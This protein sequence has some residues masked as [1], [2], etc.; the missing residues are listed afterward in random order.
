MGEKIDRTGKE[1]VN[2]QGS[3]MIISVYNS[4]KNIT[5]YFPEHDYS[6]QSTYLN[7]K[8]GSIK[9]PYDR[10]IYN[11]GYLGEG[12]YTPTAIIEGENKHTQQYISWRH[13]LERA[14]SELY[15]E[16][17][18]TYKESEVCKEWLNFQNYAEWYD[19]NY[20]EVEGDFSCIDKDILYKG[21]KIYSPDKCIFVPN[22]INVLFTKSDAIR[23]DTPIGTTYNKKQGCYIAHCSIIVNN[24]KKVYRIGN[25]FTAEEAFF[26]YK[27]FK[28][29]YIKQVADEY[30]DKIPQKLYDAMYRYEVE[31]T[32]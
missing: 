10:T 16:R 22:R 20:Y 11:M 21:N 13:I 30:K 7:F 31:I 1:G 8:R 23:G 9:S 19:K 32:D 4:A 17:F 2:N 3:K 14:Y 5:V 28:E 29:N 18:P 24:K 15:H 6:V 12:D 27:Q 26:A 25:Y